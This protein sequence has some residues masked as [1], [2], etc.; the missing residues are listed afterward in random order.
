M[1]V[2]WKRVKT[3]SIQIL[4]GPTVRILR[5]CID[6]LK[7]RGPRTTSAHWFR[8]WFMFLN[9]K[10]CFYDGRVPCKQKTRIGSDK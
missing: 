9:L 7:S 1:L 3:S 10:G 6:F 5:S 8:P 4:R 2:W